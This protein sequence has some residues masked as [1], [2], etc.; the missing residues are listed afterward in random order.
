MMMAIEPRF[1]IRPSFRR[2]PE[3]SNKNDPAKQAKPRVCP[4]SWVFLLLDSG[5]RRND[6]ALGL[7]D[8]LGWSGLARNRLSL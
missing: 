6:E 2:R 8:N 3:S 7:M 5:L 4:T 1:S